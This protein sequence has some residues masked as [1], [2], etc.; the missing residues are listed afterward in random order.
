M[1]FWV[2]TPARFTRG[3]IS[4][5]SKLKILKKE[6]L[7]VK[8]IGGK[9]KGRNFYMPASVR[10]TQNITRKALFDILGQ[11]MD[12]I[13]FLE[14]F[15]GSGAVGLEAM[16]RGAKKVIF[17]EHDPKCA[18]VITQNLQLLLG[19]S[20]RDDGFSYELVEGDSFAHIKMFARQKKKFDLIFLDPPYGLELGKK[21]LKTLG[22]Y[23]IL[24][25]NCVVVIEHGADEI[26]PKIE[27]NLLRFEQRKY[28]KTFLSIY[29][30]QEN[31]IP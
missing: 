10:P 20:P 21:A 22:A 18:D 23:D 2:E 8:I 14:L 7:I 24:H 16:S 5:L 12:G 13:E 9:Y 3:A 29:K 1:I 27:G 6:V 19:A 17:V 28:G 11:D 26:L 15:A 25:P 4:H 30:Q 31:L